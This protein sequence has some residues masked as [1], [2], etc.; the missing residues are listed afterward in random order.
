MEDGEDIIITPG[1]V[2]AQ[3][4]RGTPK[5][6]VWATQIQREFVQKY[7]DT[8]DA[9][10]D[11]EFKQLGNQSAA[12]WIDRRNQKGMTF[13]NTFVNRAEIRQNKSRRK[14]ESI[15]RLASRPD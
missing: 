8:L 3:P 5:Q 13:I 12:F 7:G 9:L 6:V 10:T 11:A 1:R 4:T 2:L 15:A 14:A